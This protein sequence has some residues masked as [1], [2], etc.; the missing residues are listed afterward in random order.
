MEIHHIFMC[1]KKHEIMIFFDHL[2]VPAGT[3]F[4]LTIHTNYN[5]TPSNTFSWA[6]APLTKVTDA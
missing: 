3:T 1:L 2:V 4:V 5:S 6:I